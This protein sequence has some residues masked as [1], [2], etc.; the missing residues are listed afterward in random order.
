MPNE[1]VDGLMTPP[2]RKNLSITLDLIT[3]KKSSNHEMKE[4]VLD[5]VTPPKQDADADAGGL[6]NAEE[7]KK[8]QQTNP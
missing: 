1:P 5:L 4:W 6:N 7:S 3:P 2:N 8:E